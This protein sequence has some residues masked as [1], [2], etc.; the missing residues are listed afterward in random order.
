MV[1]TRVDVLNRRRRMAH[2][3]VG[4]DYHSAAVREGRHATVGRIVRSWDSGRL[5]D[6][7]ARDGVMRQ[8]AAK[9][10]VYLCGDRSGEQDYSIDLEADLPFDD[11]AFE[12]TLALD[13][14]EHVDDI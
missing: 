2:P 13:V 8:F 6:I 7:G 1:C 11:S 14:L 5:L 9:D 12:Y 4:T 3:R 10:L